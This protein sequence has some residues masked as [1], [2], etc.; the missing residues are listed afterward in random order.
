MKTIKINILDV[1]IDATNIPR[2][3]EIID[4]WVKE[5]TP[6]YVCVVP[7]HSVMDAQK[8]E[9]FK[10][11]LNQAS[12]TVPDGKPLSVIGKWS[13]FEE[14]DRVYGPDLMLALCERSVEKGYSHFLYGGKEGVAD[15]LK[16][17]LC[18]EFP[19]LN[20]VGTYSP[21][22]RPLTKEETV[23]L[24]VQLEECK[25]DILWVGLGAP[26]Q[27]KWMYA[28][29][30]KVHAK[31]MIGVGAAFD[32]LS[33]E[34]KQAPRWMMKVSLEWFFRLMIEPRRLWKRYVFGNTLFLLLLFRE[35]I[36]GQFVKK[37]KRGVSRHA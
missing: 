29:L 16:E 2:V 9:N 6:R 14:M 22:F 36:T 20:I 1:L 19:G 37:N 10:A 30:G 26:K 17:C 15:R 13:G 28:H 27:E 31:V 12:L 3:C 21:P 35:I 33:G 5:G 11:I 23:A 18:E 24:S 25:P 7:V 4:D 34:K 32:F 8:D